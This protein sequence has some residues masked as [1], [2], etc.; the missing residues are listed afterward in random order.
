[1]AKEQNLSLNPT[2]I[3]GVCGR[4]MCCLK[5]EDDNYVQTRKRMPRMGKDV[6][7]P[8]GFGTVID[9]NILKEAVTVR[10][11]RDDS[12]EIKT[13]PMNDIVWFKMDREGAHAK[14]AP[15]TK[16]QGKTPFVRTDDETVDDTDAE[17]SVLEDDEEATPATA[18]D[19]DLAFASDDTLYEQEPLSE[20]IDAGGAAANDWQEEVTQALNKSDGKN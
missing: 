5:Y 1:M 16:I 17:V 4:L 8:D 9:L 15:E 19:G 6:E 13:Y 14:G 20:E 10:I 11:H 2:K 12:N 3:S 18:D 7:T